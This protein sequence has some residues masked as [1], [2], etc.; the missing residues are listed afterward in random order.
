MVA[1]RAFP[2][3][4]FFQ[5][6]YSVWSIP[7]QYPHLMPQFS[8][9]WGRPHLP[10]LGLRSPICGHI[11]AKWS[12][13]LHIWHAEELLAPG[14]PAPK[15]VETP[16]LKKNTNLFFHHCVNY[17]S[18]LRTFEITLCQLFFLPP[19]NVFFL[20]IMNNLKHIDFK[21]N[22]Q[23]KLLY[24]RI[25][26]LMKLLYLH[27]K[28]K[29]LLKRSTSS[30]IVPNALFQ[31]Q[32]IM[33]CIIRSTPNTIETN[34]TINMKTCTQIHEC[35]VLLLWTWIPI[36]CRRVFWNMKNETP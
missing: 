22:L 11:V 31:N 14:D 17:P 21:L 26:L 10:H 32:S 35:C 25:L 8:I 15:F 7:E 36:I 13:E 34:K 1:D 30:N 9:L 28:K 4:P 19:M 24:V 29:K 12:F 5:H 3:F 20:D 23:N 27:H 6:L 2:S 33:S 16:C 18:T